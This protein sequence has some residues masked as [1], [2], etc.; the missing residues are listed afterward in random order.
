MPFITP[1]A[2]TSVG[3]AGQVGCGETGTQENSTSTIF[4]VSILNQGGMSLDNQPIKKLIT[5]IRVRSMHTSELEMVGNTP[6]V[7]ILILS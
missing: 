3:L 5:L 7:T 1:N 2:K 4:F 6:N